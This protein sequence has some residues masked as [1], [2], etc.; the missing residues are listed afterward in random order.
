MAGLRTAVVAWVQG[1]SAG[2]AVRV[3]FSRSLD[4]LHLGV[5]QELSVHLLLLRVLLG[6]AVL[7][8]LILLP[9]VGP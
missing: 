8:L 6:V 9:M 4:V 2:A 3:A 1:F 7:A 5:A